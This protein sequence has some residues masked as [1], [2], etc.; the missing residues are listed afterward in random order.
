MIDTHTHLSHSQF[1]R[2]RDEVIDR[3]GAAGVEFVIDVGIDP[4]TSRAAAGLARRHDR[5]YASIGIHPHDA[6]RHPLADLSSLE[7]LLASERVVAV[8]E[9]GLDFFRDYAPRDLQEALFRS[10]IEVALRHRLPLIVHSRGAEGLV[11]SILDEM[12]A[13]DVGGVLHCYAGDADGVSRGSAI[14]FYFGFGGS[15]TRSR[16]KYRSLLP[17]VPR[18][19][20][21]LETDCPYL[22]PA[23]KT[24]RRNEPAFLNEVLPVMAELLGLPE[25]GVRARTDANAR[26]LF[27][28]PDGT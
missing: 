20:L 27:R 14:G 24:S 19:R 26:R 9:T 11:V 21:L 3:A 6:G 13:G 15:I 16:S 8:G 22:A 4:A 10:H 17:E 1:D 7:P 28:L 5:I 18:D 23:P 2:D 12:G 25:A